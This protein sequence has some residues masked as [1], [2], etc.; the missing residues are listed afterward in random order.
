MSAPDVP[1]E[2]RPRPG[3]RAEPG[4]AMSTPDVLAR[5]RSPQPR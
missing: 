1:A 3:A 5:K 4:A 2:Q